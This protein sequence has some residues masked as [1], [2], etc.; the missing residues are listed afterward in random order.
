MEEET[1]ESVDP[2]EGEVEAKAIDRGICCRVVV[3]KQKDSAGL[4]RRFVHGLRLGRLSNSNVSQD[5]TKSLKTIMSQS[6]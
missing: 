4:G 3:G 5:A 6:V 2:S 1:H